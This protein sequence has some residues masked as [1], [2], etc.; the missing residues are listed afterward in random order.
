MGMNKTQQLAVDFAR[1]GF[2]GIYNIEKFTNQYG[3]LCDNKIFVQNG[4]G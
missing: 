3:V 1:W 4:K 2:K